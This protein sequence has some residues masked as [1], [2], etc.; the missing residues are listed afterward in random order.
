MPPTSRR[1]DDRS[2]KAKK[3][4]ARYDRG[5]HT[6]TR[7]KAKLKKYNQQVVSRAIN[8]NRL[9]GVP[10]LL[11]KEL[12]LSFS[13]RQ[14]LIFTTSGHST[15]LGG[16][17]SPTLIKIN[18]LDPAAPVNLTSAGIITVLNYQGSTVQP[19]FH[20]LNPEP[21]LQSKLSQYSDMYEKV[22]VT[23]SQAKVRVQGVANQHKLM[24]FPVNVPGEG[25]Q[26]DG[27]SYGSNYMPYQSLS[28]P[29]LDG[30]LYIW[31]VK[32]RSEGQL[33]TN[34]NGLNL[35]EIRS[36]VPGIRMK[37]HNVY[38]NGTTSK[39]VI[40][41]STYTP[42]WLG[43]KDW[44]DNLDKIQFN[45]DGS[46]A[47][48]HTENCYQY[49]G[50]TNR[51]PSSA[52]MEPARVFMDIKVNYNVKYIQRKNDPASGDPAIPRA[53]NQHTDL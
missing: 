53:S 48:N 4:G 37:K 12:S 6:D 16:M 13:Y 50:I 43:I 11:P 26:G 33:V 18:L 38:A 2:A 8:S 39:A 30:E 5:R 29:T 34:N 32:Q 20:T 51:I 22:V 46:S 9:L 23:G 17:Y 49:L 47:G 42:K 1:N 28:Q 7:S 52:A 24:P 45:V 15:A 21:N 40:H 3:R 44:R 27:N 25:H 14:L 10:D 41:S 35:H 19:I 31:S 36:E